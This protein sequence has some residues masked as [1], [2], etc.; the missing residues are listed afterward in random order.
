MKGG[1][2]GRAEGVLQCYLNRGMKEMEDGKVRKRNV[3]MKENGKKHQ[4][5]GKI[6]GTLT[7]RD[8]GGN[9]NEKGEWKEQ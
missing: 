1:R 4:R 6:K 7:K 8:N 2:G 5:E 9:D 3:T